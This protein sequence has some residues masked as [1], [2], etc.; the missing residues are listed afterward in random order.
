MAGL[1][2]EDARDGGTIGIATKTI[3]GFTAEPFRYEISSGT[4]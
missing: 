4:R 1:F 3:P 2:L